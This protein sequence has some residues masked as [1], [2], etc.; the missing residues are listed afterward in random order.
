MVTSPYSNRAPLAR[1]AARWPGVPGILPPLV[2]LTDPDRTPDVL[3]F[4]EAL[5]DGCALIYRH[6]EAA[7]HIEIAGALALIAERKGLTFLI[8]AD[9]ALAEAVEADGV[10]WP[11]R[12][13]RAARDWRRTH[14]EA[15]MTMSAHDRSELEQ[16]ARCGAD[17]ALLSPVFTT[18]SAGSGEALGRFRAAALVRQSPLPVYALGGVNARTARRLAGTG[19]SGLAGIDGLSA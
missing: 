5:P 9:P 2:A 4:A 12:L 19:F 14:A 3:A 18:R 13:A 17:A 1:L 8:A 15:V 10:H 11:A 7:D 6:F 16:A